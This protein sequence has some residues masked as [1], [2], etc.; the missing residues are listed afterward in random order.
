MP[1]DEV[2]RTAQTPGPPLRSPQ[3]GEVQNHSRIC[4]GRRRGTQSCGF[5]S[6]LPLEALPAA[7]QGHPPST[8]GKLEG[9]MGRLCLRV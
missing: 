9:W 1:S 4:R 7:L 5:P 3:P 2:R 8:A 6:G